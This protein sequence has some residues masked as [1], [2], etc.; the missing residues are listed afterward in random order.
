MERPSEFQKVERCLRGSEKRVAAAVKSG[1]FEGERKSTVFKDTVFEM[2][3]DKVG[4]I[5]LYRLF[6]KVMMSDD[7]QNAPPG[8]KS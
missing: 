5:D 8:P 1:A 4:E 3:V 2:A 6:F 7:P